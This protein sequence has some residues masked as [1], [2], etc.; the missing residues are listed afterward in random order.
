MSFEFIEET[1]KYLLDGEPL[2]SVTEILSP[3]QAESF[4]AINPM[5]LQAAADRGTAVHEITEAMDYDM[6]YEDMI[7]P[8]L[9]PYVDAYDDFLMDHECEW[10]GVEMPVHFFEQYAGTVD[11]FGYI[12]GVPAV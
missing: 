5:V 1:H 12:D 8:D 11:R 10:E 2:P 4:A 6:D 7:S 9:V 3:L